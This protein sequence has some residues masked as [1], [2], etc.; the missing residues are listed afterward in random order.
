MH[1]MFLSFIFAIQKKFPQAVA[2]WKCSATFGNAQTRNRAVENVSFA[3][4]ANNCSF[5]GYVLVF[6]SQHSAL[7][8]FNSI[9]KAQKI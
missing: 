5:S 6:Y 4:I 1:S 7:H 8:Y 9:F 2:C 3:P